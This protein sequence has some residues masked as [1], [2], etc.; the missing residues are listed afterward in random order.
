MKECTTYAPMIGAREGELSAGERTGLAAHL[1][2][3]AACRARLADERALEGL[4]GE[5]LLRAAAGRDFAD[6]ADGV[7]ARVGATRPSGLRALLA[8]FRKH[9]VAAAAS[10]LA[11]T[12]AA[13]A[14][15]VYFET[16]GIT[17]GP[18]AG[19]VEVTSEEHTPMVLNTSDGPLILLGDSDEPEGT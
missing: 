5:A 4:L 8:W 10:A 16:R 9:R 13:L 1:E 14:L 12:L 17:A 18:L 3:C 15:I 7:M 6:F 19:D 11:P 2:A